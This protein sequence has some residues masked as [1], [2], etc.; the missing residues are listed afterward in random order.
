MDVKKSF[1]IL[2]TI[3]KWETA[4]KGGCFISFLGGLHNPMTTESYIE[5]HRL[6]ETIKII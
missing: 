3:M 5:W 6:E 1:F 2:W 4:A